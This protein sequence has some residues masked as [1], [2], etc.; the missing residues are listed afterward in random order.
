MPALTN[1]TMH[2]GSSSVLGGRGRRQSQVF[3]NKLKK[4]MPESGS[5]HGGSK[6]GSQRRNL[7]TQKHSKFFSPNKEAESS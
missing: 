5:P 3:I 6:K 1:T 2:E 4:T 7:T